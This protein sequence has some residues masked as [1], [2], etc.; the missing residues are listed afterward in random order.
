ML[1]T[2][3]PADAL[4]HRVEFIP[5]PMQQAFIE[6]RHKADLWACRMGEG[7]SAGLC[8]ASYAHAKE[9][10]GAVHAFVRETW[11]VLRDTTQQ[12]FFRWFPPGVVGTYKESTKTFKWAIGEMRGTVHFLGMDTP[13]DASKFQSRS[14]AGLFFDEPA[15]A[16]ASGGIDKFVFQTGMTRL[17]QPGM[18]NYVAKLAENSPD[19]SHWTHE[20]FVDPGTPGYAF[21][22]SK[23]PE[24]TK[25]LPPTYY[26][27]L[28][29]VY[30]D[31]PDLQRRFADG[32]FGFQQIGSAVTPEWRDDIH[33]SH[34][35]APVRGPS[36]F[37]CWD[38]GLNPSC[39][40]TQI[41][42]LGHWNVLESH[43]GDG[44]GVAELIEQH[45]APSMR[46]RFKGYR[47]EH[48]GDPN[49]LSPEQS[50]ARNSAV[51][52]IRRMIGGSF[53]PGPHSIPARVDPL[54]AVLRR[55]T[56]GRGVVQVDRQR[57]KE[58]YYALR[59]GWH[60][61]I[62]KGGVVHDE[63]VKNIHSHPGDA[64]AYGSAYLW[65]LSK[66]MPNGR[67]GGVRAP[68]VRYF[69]NRGIGPAAGVGFRPPA[70][71]AKL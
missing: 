32:D 13:D 39:I 61:P 44:I 24:N 60:R 15:P 26:E 53:H 2:S 62:S 43:V 28:R 21:W 52:V 29:N 51:K 17:R 50:D 41:T 25:N 3:D 49:G 70:H 54:R 27:D 18:K 58:V 48:I 59:G 68:S 38:F 71:G 63:P 4:E 30:R 57:A 11:E 10:P 67:A 42:P 12:E 31:R 47:W 20:L 16:A 33:L 7:K 6:S 34:S 46:T 22:R 37:L 9:N 69:G 35:L 5:N 56:N 40:V 14:L 45:V 66:L 65:P 55:M 36:L 8:W 19:E 1:R 23:E 64:L